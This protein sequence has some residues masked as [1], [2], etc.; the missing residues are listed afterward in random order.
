MKLPTKKTLDTLFICATRLLIYPMLWQI[1]CIK[2]VAMSSLL[3]NFF[4]SQSFDAI[5]PN[6][7]S[8]ESNSVLGVLDFITSDIIISTDELSPLDESS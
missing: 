8:T 7:Q 1:I 5:F 4:S 3:H 2:E 6:A